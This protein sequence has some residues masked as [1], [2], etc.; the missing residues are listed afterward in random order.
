MYN[1]LMLDR[2]LVSLL[3]KIEKMKKQKYNTWIKYGKNQTFSEYLM[4][5]RDYDYV[6][7]QMDRC[8]VKILRF[9]KAAGDR[10]TH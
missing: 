10:Y 9:R 6:Y 1:L 7:V 4:R 8:V 2:Q 5:Q 3:A